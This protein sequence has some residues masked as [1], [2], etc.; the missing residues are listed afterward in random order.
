MAEKDPLDKNGMIQWIP[1]EIMRN[2]S[3]S[4][5]D[6]I[7]RF[8]NVLRKMVEMAE[9]HPDGKTQLSAM[10]LYL[11]TIREFATEAAK[12]A[13]AKRNPLDMAYDEIFERMGYAKLQ[14]ITLELSREKE[15][16]P[17]RPSPSLAQPE[18]ES[19]SS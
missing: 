7:R 5:L 6:A 3:E 8:P 14:E 19:P 9:S 13:G 2:I 17:N 4:Q 11:D 16:R 18:E 15:R 10:K 1:P 12:A